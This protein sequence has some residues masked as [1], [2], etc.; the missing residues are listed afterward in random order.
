MTDRFSVYQ[1][2]ADDRIEEVLRDAGAE[3]AVLEAKR[4]TEA[5]G[6]LLG[7]VVRIAIIDQDD[8]VVFDWRRGEGV[9][10]PT[11]EQCTA[12]SAGDA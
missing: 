3:A 1:Y 6:A 9:V 10:F 7:A 2:L 5:P 11:R 12:A 4:R 8:F